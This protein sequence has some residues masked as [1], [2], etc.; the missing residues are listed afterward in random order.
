MRIDEA[1]AE[2][3]PLAVKFGSS[4]LNIMYRQ[5]NYTIAQMEEME[6]RKSEPGYLVTMI[7]DL[8]E[9]WDLNRVEKIFADDGVTV[10]GER[11][12]P[13][14]VSSREDVRLYVTRPVIVG[15][16]KAIREDGEVGEA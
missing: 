14:D 15:I 13:V 8:V 5:S 11:E 1:L 10:V 6:G 3:K 2:S 9:A 16:L 4:V 7:Q 12:V